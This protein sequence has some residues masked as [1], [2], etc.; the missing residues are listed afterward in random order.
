MASKL[1]HFGLWLDEDLDAELINYLEPFAK[2]RRMGELF[3]NALACYRGQ[4]NAPI[5]APAPITPKAP[6]PK[7]DLL[8][9]LLPVPET[10]TALVKAKFRNAFGGRH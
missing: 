8:P 7:V 2:K 5:I 3:R 9:P 10:E 4:P 1:R 6:P